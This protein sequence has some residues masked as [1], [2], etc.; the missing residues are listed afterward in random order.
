LRDKQE[1]VRGVQGRHA[2]VA[3]SCT[4]KPGGTVP[5]M[6]F[7]GPIVPEKTTEFLPHLRKVV[8]EEPWKLSYGMLDNLLFRLIG[9]YKGA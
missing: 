3:H 9:Y 8:K 2:E 4:H 7:H 6:E 5:G 1:F